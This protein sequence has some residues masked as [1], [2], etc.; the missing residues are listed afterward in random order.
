MKSRAERYL[1]RRIRVRR[2]IYGTVECPRLS[3]YRSLKH[4]YAQI[5]DDAEGK[6]IV[7]ASTKDKGFPKSTGIKAAAQVGQ[8]VGKKAIQKGIQKVVFDRGARPYHGRVKAVAEG[9]REAGL[10]F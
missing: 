1:F 10:K 2:K 9:A 8:V 6:T 7:F 5:I 4:I 3:V